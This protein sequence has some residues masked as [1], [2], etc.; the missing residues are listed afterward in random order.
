MRR[1]HPAT[2]LLSS[3]RC[4]SRCDSKEGL[5]LGRRGS[6]GRQSHGSL[7]LKPHRCNSC[8]TATA[9]LTLPRAL[10]TVQVMREKVRGR[11][12]V[13]WQEV[14]RDFELICANAMKYNQ[15]RRCVAV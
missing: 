6:C 8:S 11:A 15:R 13:N 2:T 10:I 1:M 14:V 4:A 7:R 9:S 5:N 12:Y 3:S